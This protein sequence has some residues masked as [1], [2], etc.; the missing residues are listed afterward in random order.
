M[1]RHCSVPMSALTPFGIASARTVAI[2]KIYLRRDSLKLGRS[3]AR[4]FGGACL[5]SLRWGF[6]ADEFMTRR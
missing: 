1:L 2:V 4:E 3:E 5:R 6:A